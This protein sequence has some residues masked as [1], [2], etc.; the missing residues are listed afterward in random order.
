MSIFAETVSK[1]ISDYRYLLRRYLPQ[2]DRMHKLDELN[3]KDPSIYDNDASLYDVAWSIVKDI[4]AN[5]K[6]PSQGYYSY[7]G[8]EHYCT[9][10]K[11]YLDN[12][13]R[14]G[15]AIIHKA[16]RA[17][18]ALIDV[19]QLLMLPENRL[20]DS[21]AAKIKQYAETVAYYGSDEQKQVF[22]NSIDRQA[23]HNSEFFGPLLQGYDEL[24]QSIKANTEF[25]KQETN[26]EAA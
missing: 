22:R 10:L 2:A 23:E 3:L 21:I 7:S 18:R 16:Q 26:A 8:I 17:S 6:I 25:I 19:I 5:V 13:E 11:E 14:E 9:Y 12:Y 4:E 15:D 1:A 20:S 24:E